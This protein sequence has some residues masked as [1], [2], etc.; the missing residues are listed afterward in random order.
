MIEVQ[1]W[2]IILNQS[3]IILLFV[4]YAVVSIMLRVQAKKASDETDF[5]IKKILKDETE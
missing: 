4:A 5:L 3:V 2:L 1:L